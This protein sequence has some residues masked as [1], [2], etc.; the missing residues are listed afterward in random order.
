MRNEPVARLSCQVPNFGKKGH[1]IGNRIPEFSV[2]GKRE[3]VER[4]H[5]SY[6]LRREWAGFS[7]RRI[8]MRILVRRHRE[9]GAQCFISSVLTQPTFEH[10]LLLFYV[11]YDIHPVEFP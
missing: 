9:R 4:D 3:H 2:G 8:G 10:R 5:E 1:D 11:W 7:F 6:V